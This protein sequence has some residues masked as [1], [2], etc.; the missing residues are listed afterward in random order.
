MGMATCVDT[1]IALN[2]QMAT[3]MATRMSTYI[4]TSDI[5]MD[6]HGNLHVNKHYMATQGLGVATIMPT[7]KGVSTVMATDMTTFMAS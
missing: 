6:G 7:C 1:Y 3:C 5:C 2:M 4:A